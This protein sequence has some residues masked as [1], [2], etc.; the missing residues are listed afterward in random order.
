MDAI[1]DNLGY[2]FRAIAASSSEN[3]ALIDLWGGRERT[4]AT[5]RLDQRMDTRRRAALG[6]WAVG[7]RPHGVLV[8]NRGEFV[9][10]F[11]GAMRAGIVPVPL[12]IKQT[13]TI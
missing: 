8:G 1:E 4:A 13:P 11:F 12:N 10:I 7:R 3:T 2:F 5:T 6:A 9:E